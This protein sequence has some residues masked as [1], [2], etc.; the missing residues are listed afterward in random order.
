VRKGFHGGSPGELATDLDDIRSG[1]LRA[2]SWAPAA[3]VDTAGH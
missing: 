3:G 1:C 2:L